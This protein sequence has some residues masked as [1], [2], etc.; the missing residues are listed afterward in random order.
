MNGIWLT[1]IFESPQFD[2]GYDVSD[3]FQVLAEYGT[4]E[5]FDFLVARAR[6]R[7]IAVILDMIL[8]HTSKAHPWSGVC[9]SRCDDK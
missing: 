4:L 7:G 1:P 8:G 3:Y 6:E 5:D 2:Y 9:Q